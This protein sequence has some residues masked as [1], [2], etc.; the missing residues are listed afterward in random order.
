[1][2]KDCFPGHQ[3]QAHHLKMKMKHNKSKLIKMSIQA[4]LKKTLRKEN[5]IELFIRIHM[6]IVFLGMLMN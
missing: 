1:M 5:V 3:A 4:I 6:N 2:L